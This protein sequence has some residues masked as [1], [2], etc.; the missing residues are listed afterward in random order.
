M[1]PFLE[2]AAERFPNLRGIKYSKP[3]FTELQALLAAAG[4]K[5]EI[6]WGCDDVLLAALTY[7]VHGAVG[8]TYNHSAP[9][10]LAMWESFTAGNL[11]E[12]RNISRTIVAMV[13]C[14]RGHNV[15]PT[16][17]ALLERQGIPVGP[18][19]PPL[20]VTLPQTGDSL[21]KMFTEKD[22]FSPNPPT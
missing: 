3:D 22:W 21:Y 13:A 11:A 16:Q 12:A 5:Y 9:L 14:L 7:G 18:P 17:K 1:V 15:I 4:D 6:L 10:Y 8:S 20:S 2:R 19:R